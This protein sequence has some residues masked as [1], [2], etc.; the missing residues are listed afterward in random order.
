[1]QLSFLLVDPVRDHDEGQISECVGPCQALQAKR[2]ELLALSFS[3]IWRLVSVSV[4]HVALLG[5]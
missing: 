5:P 1:M 4:Q 2:R 3:D